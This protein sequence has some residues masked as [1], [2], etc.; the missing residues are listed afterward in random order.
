MVSLGG[1]SRKRVI[2]AQQQAPLGF[3]GAYTDSTGER[4][5]PVSVQ[6]PTRLN[7]ITL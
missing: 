6:A 2:T 7:A 1:V 4:V 3:Y 5:D